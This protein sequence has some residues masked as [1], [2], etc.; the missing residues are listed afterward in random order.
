MFKVNAKYCQENHF[1]S[2]C[3]AFKDH[4]KVSTLN[5]PVYVSTC[6]KKLVLRSFE[7]TCSLL[8][9]H[10]VREISMGE[11]LMHSSAV[12][13]NPHPSLGRMRKDPE[14]TVFGESRS[15]S[16]M[17]VCRMVCIQ[18]GTS[19]VDLLKSCT[20]VCEQK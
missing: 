13:L 2:S 15:T 9:P 10:Q 7:P 6:N 3:T 20:A 16:V 8:C 12:W 14:I 17:D 11:F 19:E 18:C 1:H 5:H 4:M